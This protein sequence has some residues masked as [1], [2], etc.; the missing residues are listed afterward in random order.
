MDKGGTHVR[1]IVKN[2]GDGVIAAEET[3]EPLSGLV[4]K[5]YTSAGGYAIVD[6][7]DWYASNCDRNGK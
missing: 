1:L 6:M 4:F 5:K 3:G 2:T 7:Q